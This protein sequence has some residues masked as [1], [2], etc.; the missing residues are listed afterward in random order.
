ML[1]KTQ[2]LLISNLLLYSLQHFC[3]L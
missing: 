2:N 1:Q 3:C